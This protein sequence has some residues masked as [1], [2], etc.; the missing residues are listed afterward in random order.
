MVPGT[1]TMVPKLPRVE[2]AAKQFFE[3]NP[4]LALEVENK[5][6]AKYAVVASNK[7]TNRS[8]LRHKKESFQI[9]SIK[10]GDYVQFYTRLS[11]C[12]DVKTTRPSSGSFFY[13]GG[14]GVILNG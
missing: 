5:I 4:E 9:T 6:K 13:V 2:E 7:R 11:L 12:S 14:I 10:K 3:D 1:V 8:L